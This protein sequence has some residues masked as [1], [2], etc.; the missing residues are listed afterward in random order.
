MLQALIF[1]SIK[2][3]LRTAEAMEAR[4]YSP[5]RR[6]ILPRIRPADLLFVAFGLALA[7]LAFLGT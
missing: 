4:A 7:A 2:N 5:G 3:S 1:S 6:I